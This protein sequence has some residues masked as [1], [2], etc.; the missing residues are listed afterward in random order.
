LAL[1]I[2]QYKSNLIV[3]ENY[4]P[5]FLC[6]LLKT[7]SYAIVILLCLRMLELNPGLFAE[8]HFRSVSTN[9]R[10]NLNHI[11]LDLNRNLDKY[12]PHALG[13]VISSTLG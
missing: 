10:L 3:T 7:A 12:Q 9:T 2:L 6:A 11:K 13:G 1:F 4:L 8:L 5:E